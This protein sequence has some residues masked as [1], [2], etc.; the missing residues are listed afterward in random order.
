MSS[1]AKWIVGIIVLVLIVICLWYTFGNKSATPA[2]ETGPIKIGFLGPLT[3]DMATVGQNN[4]AAVEVAVDAVNKAGGINGRQI[5]M[6]WEDGKC[7][8]ASGASAAQKLVNVDKV[9]AIIGGGCSAESIPAAP[10]IESGKVVAIS[11]LSS[12]PALTSA[13]DYIFRDY[14]SDS[15]QGAKAAE[16][17]INKLGAKK[18]AILACQSDWCNGLAKVFADKAKT[19]GGE[20]VVEEKFDDKTTKDLRTELT[21]IKAAK[22]DLIYYLA[23]SDSTII[24]FKQMKELGIKAKV[25][26]GDTWDDPKI[27]SGAGKAAE[28]AIY[29]KPSALVTDD[30]KSLMK[31]KTGSEDI[32]VGSSQAYDAVNI[33]IQVMKQVGSDSTK[34]K[35]ALYQVQNYQGV[36]GAI[37]FDSNG[38]LKDANYDVK[39]ITNGKPVDYK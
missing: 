2:T 23:Y 26:G 31:A 18:L 32:L 8:G 5:E 3:G 36:S 33:L 38:D 37:S 25:L 22:P 13:G 4:K 15:F 21:K 28:G 29:L 39:V 35:D 10:I 6:V 12:N 9:V 16:F 24:G 20:I 14:P 34:I 7:D 17:A 11:P 27:I 30:F 19:L 1:T